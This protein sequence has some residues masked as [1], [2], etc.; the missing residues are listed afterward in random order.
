MHKTGDIPEMEKFIEE[1]QKTT[2]THD[3]MLHQKKYHST[4]RKMVSLH[5]S[6]LEDWW[7]SHSEHYEY[8][9]NDVAAVSQGKHERVWGSI[10]A[11]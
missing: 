9:H 2:T 10:F 11:V 5:E 6:F 7:P 4:A 8:G 1:N 3:C